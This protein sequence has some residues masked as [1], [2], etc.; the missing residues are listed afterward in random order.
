[1]FPGLRIKQSGYVSIEDSAMAFTNFEVC[2]RIARYAK[3]SVLNVMIELIE[4]VG[5]TASVS[6]SAEMRGYRMPTQDD[7]TLAETY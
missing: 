7:W 4:P 6:V 3:S 5:A 2:K 1:M